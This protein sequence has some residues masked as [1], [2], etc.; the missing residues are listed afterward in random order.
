MNG[1][2]RGCADK[3]KALTRLLSAFEVP[4]QTSYPFFL[5]Q[6]GS[7]R[8]TK[9]HLIRNFNKCLTSCILHDAD[10]FQFYGPSLRA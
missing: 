2:K 9:L 1:L 4:C 8:L 5:H 6:V 10:P 7:V 3:E